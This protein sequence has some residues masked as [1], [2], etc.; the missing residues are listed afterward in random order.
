[1]QE[2]DAGAL[3]I[4]LARPWTKLL[5]LISTLCSSVMAHGDCSRSTHLLGG[6]DVYGTCLRERPVPRLFF[7]VCDC[8]TDT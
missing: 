4:Q 6:Q 7:P 2:Q 1:M 8:T 3:V 5:E